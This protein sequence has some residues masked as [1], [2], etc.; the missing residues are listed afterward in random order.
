MSSSSR[1]PFGAGPS[2]AGSHHGAVMFMPSPS[3]LRAQAVWVTARNWAHGLYG[4][5]GSVEVVTPE[6]SYG[7]SELS[8]LT[9]PSRPA[10]TRA[11]TARRAQDLRTAAKDIVLA[12][13]RL[14]ETR[15]SIARSEKPRL[16]WQHH[17]LFFTPASTRAAP[18]GVPVVQFVDAMHVWESRRWGVSRPGYGRTLER[19]GE[20]PQLLSADLVLCVSNE[21]AES[22]ALASVDPERII[23]TPCT[24]DDRLFHPELPRLGAR[25]EYGLRPS[26]VVFGWV[27]S[28]RRFHGLDTAIRAFAGIADD[29]PDAKLLLVG[30][31][32]QKRMM[33]DL[34]ASLRIR[35]RVVLTGGVGHLE[36]P[37]L[38][39][40]M[41]VALLTASSSS[42]FHYSPLKLREYLAAGKPIVAPE[43]GQVTELL[44]G[45]IGEGLYPVGDIGAMSTIM[46]RLGTDA[47]RRARASELA[48]AIHRREGGIDRQVADV[49]SRL[50]L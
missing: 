26:D 43:V 38:V 35:D 25:H 20:R 46:R 41:D 21:V 47:E 49:M 19:L 14:A 4:A 36:V 50:G 24:A 10:S 33:M 34:A 29:V 42:E 9:L 8:L 12:R 23:V 44:A 37:T 11:A 3:S 32:P 22:V 39:G 40:A 13:R 15:R 48:L 2:P 31:G 27:G 18:S 7:L 5:L 1:V 45:R 16:I 17:D 28:F 30:E 6:R